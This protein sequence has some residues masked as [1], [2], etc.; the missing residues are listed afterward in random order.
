MVF[1][2][3]ILGQVSL[4]HRFLLYKNKDH[5]SC[6]L[7]FIRVLSLR[8][9]LLVEFCF[10]CFLK[11]HLTTAWAGINPTSQTTSVYMWNSIVK[12]N[13]SLIMF[14]TRYFLTYIILM[15]SN[16]YIK[17]HKGNWRKTLKMILNSLSCLLGALKNQYP[18]VGFC[19]QEV[20]NFW[21]RLKFITFSILY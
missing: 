7:T 4:Y 16:K 15:H 6:L 21:F 14:T 2:S 20:L 19:Y 13:I 9:V 1:L 12:A 8:C 10:F 3:H 17:E 11:K 18:R 5:F